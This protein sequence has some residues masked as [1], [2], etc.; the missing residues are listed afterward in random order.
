MSLS[1]LIRMRNIS[2]KY[3]REN[4]NTH[5]MFNNFSDNNA[6]YE[7]MCKNI[8][9]PDRQRLTVWCMHIACWITKSTITHSVYVAL[10]AFSLQQWFHERAPI[11]RY[12]Y[13]ACLF[14]F[15]CRLWCSV[16]LAQI[17][18]F[19]VGLR[20]WNFVLQAA[21]FSAWSDIFSNCTRR[22]NYK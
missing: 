17:F 6:V 12:V 8:V 2:D 9:E 13:L 1:V 21:C 22:Q 7:I 15:M 4:Q 3:C 19:S 10:T 20:A 5:F 16:E 14:G 11:L 18:V